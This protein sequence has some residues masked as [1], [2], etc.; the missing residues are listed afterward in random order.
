MTLLH[1][2]PLWLNEAGLQMSSSLPMLSLKW[3]KNLTSV[4]TIRAKTVSILFVLLTATALAEAPPAALISG[5]AQQGGLLVYQTDSDNRVRLDGQPLYLDEQGRFVIGFHRDDT[6]TQILEIETPSGDKTTLYL[7]PETRIYKT[8]RINGLAGKYVTPPQKRLDR[9]KADREAVIAAR[10]HRG[11]SPEFL[12]TGFDWPLAGQITGIYG[13]QRILNGQPRQP[14]FGIDIAA[15]SGTPITAPA[16]G[17]ITMVRD[18][19]YTG[20]TVIISHGHYISSTYSHLLDVSVYEGQAVQAGE[21]LGHVGS[22]GR[23]TGPHLD[24][25]FNWRDKRLDPALLASGPIQSGK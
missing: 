3:V 14:H 19:Y 4:V 24:W 20:W 9:I 13:S 16:A 1:A 10:Q 21:T 8:Q 18:L 11:S 12:E 5:K 17:T 23:S 7:T 6:A 2:A 15:P 25:R 22:T